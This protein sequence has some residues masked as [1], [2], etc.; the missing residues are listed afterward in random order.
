MISLDQSK[1]DIDAYNALVK[2]FGGMLFWWSIC[3]KE[4]NL[5]ETKNLFEVLMQNASQ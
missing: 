1:W 4:G 2:S 5:K 3:K